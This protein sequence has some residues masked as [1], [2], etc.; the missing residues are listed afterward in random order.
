MHSD[1]HYGTNGSDTR[2]CDDATQQHDRAR[3]AGAGAS[4]RSSSARA[5]RARGRSSLLSLG[6][7]PVLDGGALRPEDAERLSLLGSASAPRSRRLSPAS[8][9]LL[10]LRFG[11]STVATLQAARM[12]D[13]LSKAARRRSHSVEPGSQA[14]AQGNREEGQ[15]G[16]GEAK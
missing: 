9:P 7:G 2:V 3:A 14:G 1:V 8:S 16:D 5:V 13:S 12:V 11:H 10:P 4:R 6:E 15:M